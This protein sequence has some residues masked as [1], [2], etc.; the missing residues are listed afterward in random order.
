MK[1]SY[2]IDACTNNFL[3]EIDQNETL[4][5]AIPKP[6]NVIN[7][8]EKTS[9]QKQSIFSSNRIQPAA[10]HLESNKNK[11][12]NPRLLFC[13]II[14]IIII[15]SLVFIL[16]LIKLNP[17]N[18]NNS[19][20]LDTV[21]TTLSYIYQGSTF[22][23]PFQCYSSTLS[24][25]FNTS[26]IE[27]CNNAYSCTMTK[28]VVKSNNSTSYLSSECNQL[29]FDFNLISI[30]VNQIFMLKICYSQL[31]NTESA[32]IESFFQ[33]DTN[34]QINKTLVSPLPDLN[35]LTE[36]KQCYDCSYCLFEDFDH[37]TQIQNCPSNGACQVN[38]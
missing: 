12:L 22:N 8:L 32:L 5:I 38:Y 9:F 16:V 23:Q 14:L 26:T 10:N 21:P 24:S 27:N 33:N 17:S 35:N 19:T 30:D 25:F 1:S 28:T 37:R 29:R 7:L 36:V 20:T 2:K 11:T 34:C 6:L 31:C 13:I 15:I 4:R 3:I 18:N